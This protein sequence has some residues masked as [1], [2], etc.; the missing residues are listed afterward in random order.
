MRDEKIRIRFRLSKIFTVIGKLFLLFVI[1]SGGLVLPWRWLVP[2]TTSFIMQAEGPTVDYQWRP[3]EQIAPHLALAVIAAEDQRFP[4][5]YGI[6][7]HEVQAALAA[8]RRGSRLRGAST[9]TQQVAKNLYLWPDRHWFRKALEWWFALWIEL[10]WNKQRI[11]EVYLNIAQFGP[12]IYG[13]EAAS[14]AY[15]R[16]PAEELN[17][18]KAAALAA[19]LPAPKRYQPG[20]ADQRLK[21]RQS[22]ILKQMDR[23]GGLD[24]LQNLRR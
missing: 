15:F 17:R 24:Y 4:D 3:I 2:P 9:I 13:A 6:D 18:S 1:V 23:L 11:L 19:V 14:Q 5:H 10:C 22:W 21:D 16:I 8:Y 20:R 12:Q 7:F